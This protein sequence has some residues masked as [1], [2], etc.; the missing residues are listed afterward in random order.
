MDEVKIIGE[1]PPRVQAAL[2]F[3]RQC[4]ASMGFRCWELSQG[5]HH[6][7]SQELHPAQE[8][9]FRLACEC[10]GD[11]FAGKRRGRK[12]GKNGTSGLH[13]EDSPGGAGEGVA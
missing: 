10:L 9:A 6:V 13:S 11:Y 3:V 4:N 5:G 2:R 12:R 1:L 7:E 8:G